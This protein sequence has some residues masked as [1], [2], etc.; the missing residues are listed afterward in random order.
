[1]WKYS[2]FA[3][4]MWNCWTASN[5]QQ[6]S[7]QILS[8]SFWLN[9]FLTAESSS[10]RYP[11]GISTGNTFT[12]S[13]GWYGNNPFWIARAMPPPSTPARSTAQRSSLTSWQAIPS[14]S[15]EAASP[16]SS[17]LVPLSASL[18]AP[19]NSAELEAPAERYYPGAFCDKAQGSGDSCRLWQ[20]ALATSSN[21]LLWQ[22]CLVLLDYSFAVLLNFRNFSNFCKK[23]FTKS[24]SAN[25]VSQV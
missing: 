18:A 25:H 1:M 13:G 10:R 17:S 14:P 15:A 7:T 23:C 24:R 2:M 12:V 16:T 3:K 21:V 22:S 9:S 6:F 8:N 11:D 19:C 5:L 4:S 20:V